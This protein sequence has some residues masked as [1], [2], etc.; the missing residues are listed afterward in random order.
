MFL[1]DFS[2]LNKWKQSQDHRSLILRNVKKRKEIIQTWCYTQNLFVNKLK[3]LNLRPIYWFFNVNNLNHW[4]FSQKRR[5]R[6][7]MLY[8]YILEV[9]KL[10]HL[11]YM[12]PFSVCTNMLQWFIYWQVW[13]SQLDHRNEYDISHEIF[14]IWRNL[15]RH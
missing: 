15:L 8:N 1:T 7:K 4:K 14:C 2:L 10:K 11:S 3:F 6:N 9:A 5:N 12:C 13:N